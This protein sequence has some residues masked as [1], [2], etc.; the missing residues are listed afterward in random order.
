MESK[1]GDVYIINNKLNHKVL[2]GEGIDGSLRLSQHRSNLKKGIER[3][4]PL[5]E[6]YD[7]YGEDAFEFKVVI[8]SID[9][10]L[11]QSLLIEL[12][13]RLDMAYN[14]RDKSGK[15]IRKIEKGEL[16]V[17]ATIYKEIEEF[18][19]QWK[20]KIPCYEEL[21]IELKDMKA[22]FE[23]KSEKL[24]Q[25]EFKNS[26]LNSKAY[27]EETQRVAK[28]LFKK[29]API[30]EQLGKDLYDF[31][32][33]ELRRV[34]KSLSAKTIRSLQDKKSTI[35]QYI[36]FAIENK[37]SIYKCNLASAFD[38]KEK[39]EDLID[40]EAEENMIFDRDE[41]MEI[42]M[43]SDNPQDGVVVALL[44]EGLSHKNE[45]EELTNLV[46]QDVDLDEKTITV[47][48]E[49][50]E[51]EKK[52]YKI[53]ISHE[54]K[55]LVEGSINQ[56]KYI[57]IKGESTR[58]YKIAEGINVLRGL[59]GKAKVKAQIISQ[60]ILRIAEIYD[61]SYLNATIISYSGQIY[62]AKKM[63]GEAGMTLDEV[64]S[65]ILER[66]GVPDNPSSR[67]YLKTR[68]SNYTED[69]GLR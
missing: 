53:P 50:E 63:M 12:F 14:K 18:I 68:I 66:F 54:T 62:H 24:Y 2:N 19:E 27:T 16:F 39:L 13:S 43:N 65:I 22:G 58:K 44:F 67:H 46:K 45:F 33:A 38:S 69:I 32:I 47:N 41:I 26:F 64:V 9:R 30:E 10:K 61:Y 34:L 42:A 49:N 1:Y 56:E 37:K 36:N 21:L 51:G 4:K 7:R 48:R 25:R 6:D 60:R 55:I 28:S 57:S 59:R 5:Q 15:N 3:N 23:S 35:E 40:K 11:C 8:K 20:E 52:D 29:T 17:P 31:C